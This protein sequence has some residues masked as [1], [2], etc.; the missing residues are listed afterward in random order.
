MY[1]Y[2]IEILRILDGD[3]LDAMI[4]LG[5]NTWVKKRI[6]LMGIDAPEVRTRNAEEKVAGYKC[7]ERI[8][9]LLEANGNKAELISH[10]TGKYGRVIGVIRVKSHME[11]VNDILVAEGLAVKSDG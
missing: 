2:Y 1:K 9:E 3:T 7:K 11:T 4:D 5:F 8:T 6:R 10:G